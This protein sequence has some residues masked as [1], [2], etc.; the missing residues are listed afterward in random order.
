MLGACAASEREP[1]LL[2]DTT[3]LL[4]IDNTGCYLDGTLPPCPS[5]AESSLGCFAGDR[6]TF[7]TAPRW[8]DGQTVW[9]WRMS[10]CI[11]HQESAEKR[12]QHRDT[13][14]PCRPWTLRLQKATPDGLP[15]I[16][17][18]QR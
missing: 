12:R 17:S 13:D 3:A 6:A 8:S 10:P 11:Q 5:E 9:R 2:I 7:S 4:L 18:G 1:L 14:V 15:P 16:Q